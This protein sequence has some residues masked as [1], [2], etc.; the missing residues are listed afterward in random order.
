[1]RKPLK[2]VALLGLLLAG[3]LVPMLDEVNQEKARGCDAEHLCLPGYACVEAHCEPEEGTECRPGTSAACGKDLG[4]CTPG[5]RACGEE[6]RYG[7]CTGP[8]LPAEEVCNGLDDDCDGTADEGLSCGVSCA[9]CSARGRSCVQGGCGEACLNSHYKEGD[10]CLPKKALGTTCS[11]SRVCESGFCVDGSCCSTSACTTPQGQCVAATGT[12]STGTCQY[13]PRPNTTSCDDGK[14][15]TLNDK[16][17]GGGQCASGT[18]RVC[19]M[20]PGQCYASTGT[21]SG[22]TGNC[23]YAPL[24]TTTTCD[25]GN[26]CTIGDRCN[27]AGACVGTPKVC[28]TPPN[29]CQQPN[30]TCS[31]ATGAC[32]YPPQ[33]ADTSCNDGSG[34]TGFDRCDGAG[35]CTG[36]YLCCGNQYCDGTRCVCNS[37]PCMDCVID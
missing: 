32:E 35:S 31:L 28:N 10:Q 12:C 14:A 17:D 24:P 5:T 13:A 18:P 27:G 34:C 9:D 23:E 15:C 8:V 22:V 25:D 21:C 4:V 2:A 7:P 36:S 20:P 30:G 16:C 11:E 26:G 3:C 6:G 37:S 19:N 1:M 33:P 29:E